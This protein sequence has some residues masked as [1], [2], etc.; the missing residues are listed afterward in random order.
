[1]A[2]PSTQRVVNQTTHTSQAMDNWSFDQDFKENTVESLTFNPVSGQLERATAIQGNPSMVVSYNAAGD[3]VKL[4]KTIGS[5]TYTKTFSN[6][7][8]TVATT[9]NISVWS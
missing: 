5:T 4:E 1:M 7:D 9:M 2:Q 3:V 8:T 6:T